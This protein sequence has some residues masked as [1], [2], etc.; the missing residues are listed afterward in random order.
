MRYGLEIPYIARE[1]SIAEILALIG[2]GTRLR[3]TGL[4]SASEE[5]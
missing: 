5:R 4:L 2:L 1:N 3:M